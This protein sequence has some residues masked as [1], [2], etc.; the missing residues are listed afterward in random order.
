MRSQPAAEQRS[1]SKSIGSKNNSGSSS[2]KTKIV[3]IVVVGVNGVV[4]LL[5]L[6]SPLEG[7]QEPYEDLVKS[8][9]ALRG[10]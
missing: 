3:I 7:F 10:H 2:S 8:L 4:G 6:C 1:R 5:F 9:R